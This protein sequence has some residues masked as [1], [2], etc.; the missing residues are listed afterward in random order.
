MQTDPN[1][2]NY[3]YDVESDTIGLL[4]FGA[5]REFPKNTTGPYRRFLH[6]GLNGD[7]NGLRELAVEL[8]LYRSETSA[9]HRG[10]IDRMIVYIFGAMRQH[11]LFDFTDDSALQ[12]LRTI[13]TELALDRSFNEVPPVDV[14]YLQRK[15]VGLFLLGRRLRAVVPLKEIINEYVHQ[16]TC[17]EAH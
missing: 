15:A 10:M 11:E 2:A 9:V 8:G 14:L 4:D 7:L 17:L 1:F 5:A 6:A 12:N 16:D 3:S 13:G